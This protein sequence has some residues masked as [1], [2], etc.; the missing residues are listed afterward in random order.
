[1]IKELIISAQKKNNDAMMGL[2][3]HFQPLLRKY[4]RKLNVEDSYS[5]LLLYFVE[6]IQSM[7]ISNLRSPSDAVIVTY[8]NRSI[9]NCYCQ[10]IRNIIYLKQEIA[11]SA[12]TC[13]Q[14]YFLQNKLSSYDSIN[15]FIELSL[16]KHLTQ[17]EIMIIYLVFVNGYSSEYIAK[18]F[19]QSRQSINQTKKRALKKIEKLLCE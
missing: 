15:I 2:I 8:I 9:Y 6:L 18:K 5:E 11:M 16:P 4:A 1:M 13:E 7:N 10:K 19:N 17:K 3:E 12:L 14:T